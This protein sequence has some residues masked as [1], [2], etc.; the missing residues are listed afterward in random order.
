MLRLFILLMAVCSL[1]RGA[2]TRL[3]ELKISRR[4]GIGAAAAGA[5]GVM[6]IEV[7]VNLTPEVSLGAGVGTGIDYKS[8]MAKLRYFLPGE[9]VSPYVAFGAARW[10]SEG[11][12]DSLRLYP[13]FLRRMA[14]SALDTLILFPAFGVQFMQF[15]GVSFFAELQYLVHVF[16]LDH[17][18]YAG[19]GMHW[20]L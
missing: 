10:W 4:F 20:Y 1:A 2:P 18:S 8:M 9:W 5:H 12:V 3:E 16:S 14:P 13:T 6:G 7:D 17:G 15:S 11:N 19:L